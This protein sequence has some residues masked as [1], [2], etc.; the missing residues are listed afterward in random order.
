MNYENGL[1]QGQLI[2]YYPEGAPDTIS[3]WV[4]GKMEGD[5]E[6]Y[7]RNGKL[8]LKAT[9]KNGFFEGYLSEWDSSGN[10]VYRCRYKQGHPEENCERN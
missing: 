5:F 9:Y 4:K 7:D 3:H 10:L 8:L 1:K 2:L 6:S